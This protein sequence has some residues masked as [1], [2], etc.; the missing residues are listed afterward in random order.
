MTSENTTASTAASTARQASVLPQWRTGSAEV[1]R[2]L[3]VERTR[4][5]RRWVITASV[6]G[7]AVFSI[8]AAAHTASTP[9]AT[10]ASTATSASASTATTSSLTQSSAATTPNQT[11]VFGGQ[12]GSS[13]SLG[14]SSTTSPFGARVRTAT[15]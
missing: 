5:V 13:V 14:S 1:Q 10:A 8:L 12:T 7:T 6:V 11:S 4:A 9:T 2:G 15:S 3:L